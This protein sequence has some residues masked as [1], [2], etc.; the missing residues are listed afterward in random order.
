MAKLRITAST[1]SVAKDDNGKIIRQKFLCSKP[2]VLDGRILPAFDSQTTNEAFAIWIECVSKATVLGVEQTINPA[3]LVTDRLKS[4]NA[5]G[6]MLF[7]ECVI[8]DISQSESVQGN[9]DKG[10]GAKFYQ[11]ITF[12]VD[13]TGQRK[14]TEVENAGWV[15]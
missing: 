14:L 15:L 8:S 6:K 12:Q 7:L 11:T 3:E 1:T 9:V 4:A 5:S 13:R 10:N 2:V